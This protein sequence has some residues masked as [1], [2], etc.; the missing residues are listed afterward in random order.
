MKESIVP[1]NLLTVKMEENGNHR[2]IFH[3]ACPCSES[4]ETK[5]ALTPHTQKGVLN[6]KSW[7]TNTTEIEILAADIEK[8][9]RTHVYD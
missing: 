8:I 3:T 5:V 9:S 7:E 1:I 6:F 2:L 4:L